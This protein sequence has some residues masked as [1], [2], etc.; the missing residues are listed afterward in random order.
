MLTDNIKK[1]LQRQSP[2]LIQHVSDMV[3]PGHIVPDIPCFP[4]SAAA[5]FPLSYGQERLWL[6]NRLEN[7]SPAYN[8]YGSYKMQGLLNIFFLKKA[9]K[10]LVHQH[11]ILRTVFREE[12][13]QPRQ[14]ILPDQQIPV[15]QVD[16]TLYSEQEAGIQAKDIEQQEKTRIFDLVQGPLLRLIV[17]TTRNT[18]HTLLVIMHQII[19]DKQ[20][21]ELFTDNLLE[22]YDALVRGQAGELV[23][24]SLQYADYSVWQR[25]TLTPD[26]LAFLT[27]FWKDKLDGAN[28]VFDMPLDFT[29]SPSQ[30]TEGEIC[31][32]EFDE[33]LTRRLLTFVNSSALLFDVLLT[34]FNILLYRYTGQNDIVLG[35]PLWNGNLTETEEFIGFFTNTL[36]Y[37][38]RIDD[39]DSFASLLAKVK[40][41]SLAAYEHREMPFEYL[42]KAI[43]VER[44]F[45]RNPLFQISLNIYHLP[46]QEK[47]YENFKVENRSLTRQAS[48][49]DLTLNVQVNEEKIDFWFEYNKKLFLPD[50]IGRLT[51]YFSLLTV[52]ALAQP[53]MQVSRLV[54]L[55]ADEKAL[56][57]DTWNKTGRAYALPQGAHELIT[58]QASRTPQATAV[59][60]GG[61]TLSYSELEQESN[62]LCRYLESLGIGAGSAVGVHMEK[63]A[64]ILIVLL[65]IL[66]SGAFYI[67]LDPSYPIE[68]L[69]CILADSGAQ[70]V[71]TGQGQVQP[72]FSDVRCLNYATEREQISLMSAAPC[73]L[74]MRPEQTAY[75]IYTSGSTGKPKGVLVPHRALVNFLYAMQEYSFIKEM[76]RLLSVTPLSFD[77]SMLE[78]F[79]PLVVGATTVV[80]PQ[81]VAADADALLK[82]LE[83]YQ[84]QAM[85][86]TPATWQMLLETGFKGINRMTM[87]CGGEA[88]TK[89]LAEKLLATGGTLWNMYGPTETTIWSCVHQVTNDETAPIPIGRPIANTGIY[90]LDHAM[91]PVPIG[92]IGNLY[93]GG[94]GLAT[95]YHQL[96][97]LTRQRFL[98]HPY[99]DTPGARLYLTGDLAR[100]RPDGVIEY[101]GRSDF[102]V[103]VRGFRI[104]LGEIEVALQQQADVNQA[105]VIV[106]GD[107]P[108][109]KTIVAYI[110]P[111][112]EKK[113]VDTDLR[114]HLEKILP[115][116]MI[117]NL[118][119]ETESFPLTPNGKI[120][121]RVLQQREIQVK[122]EQVE[123][124]APTNEIEEILAGMW[125]EL[126]HKEQVGIRDNFFLLGGHSL[127]AVKAISRIRDS[128]E[129]ELP[130]RVI[131]QAPTIESLAKRVDALLMEEFAQ[132]DEAEALSLLNQQ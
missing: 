7:G 81:S 74:H 39:T 86:A 72:A 42:L 45:S 21:L 82:A 89:E 121:R 51:Q 103:K 67:P 126:L 117:P 104:E 119:I 53:D 50:T 19:S 102:Q 62:R 77:I 111:H 37:R 25:E 52:N 123:Y 101:Y 11:E 14:I 131:F 85:Q 55:P 88:L 108:E 87:L 76:E 107:K 3:H 100:Y 30:T 15:E 96:P 99:I 36:V 69:V 43:K 46:V 66:K 105:V 49:L 41:E 73:V 112:K 128:F 13:E 27:G 113:I 44:D 35:S 90:I 29:R 125:Q 32:F 93:I 33:V 98:K 97:D 60:A 132:M 48:P 109:D 20:S 63:D 130:L 94:S 92:V 38:T 120:D 65:G 71:I 2:H 31:R 54:Y 26:K 129:I 17:L 4:R 124:L 64:D 28:F 56:L 9:V 95:G 24:L 1:L 122:N 110:K 5:S 47:E 59:I 57:L 127:L 18:E 106:S 79:L 10:Q 12:D 80:I 75:C 78:L 61:A 22:R 34:L 91:Q 23:P 114:L 84:P 118:F 58:Q 68:R 16:L 8:I 6:L 83:F 70:V 40:A 116:Y 115:S